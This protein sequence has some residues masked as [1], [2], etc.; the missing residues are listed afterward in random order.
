MQNFGICVPFCN[1]IGHFYGP[2]I[3]LLKDE[4]FAKTTFKLEE[5]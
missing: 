2:P 5:N 1:E 4:H 3:T